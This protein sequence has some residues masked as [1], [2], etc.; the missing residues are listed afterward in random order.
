MASV[1]FHQEYSISHWGQI[2]ANVRLT[3]SEN[4]AADTN[5]TTLTLSKLEFQLVGNSNTYQCGITTPLGNCTVSRRTVHHAPSR[6]RY[7]VDNTCH[8]RFFRG[9]TIII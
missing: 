9:F 2:S 7:S 1:S 4:Y 3:F 8:L 5:K 6:R